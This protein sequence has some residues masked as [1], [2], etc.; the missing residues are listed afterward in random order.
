V[1]PAPNNR[2]AGLPK[3][4]VMFESATLFSPVLPVIWIV[5][6]GRAD[7]N[8]GGQTPFT[9]IVAG[10]VICIPFGM[11][12]T[13]P[14]FS[15]MWWVCAIHSVGLFR[16]FPP[17]ITTPKSERSKVRAAKKSALH[18]PLS[19]RE[20]VTTG[21]NSSRRWMTSVQKIEE[22][23]L[24]HCSITPVLPET[25][26]ELVRLFLSYELPRSVSFPKMSLLARRH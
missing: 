5:S 9:V 17:F 1:R 11:T 23:P 6:V 22:A 25:R 3:A 15:V 10:P 19:Q 4:M 16:L 13:S 7:P 24:L 26:S 8:D 12:V 14:S 20:L 2:A 18:S 21:P